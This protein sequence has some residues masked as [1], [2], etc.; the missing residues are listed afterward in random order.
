MTALENARLNQARSVKAHAKKVTLAG[1][2]EVSKIEIV[3]VGADVSAI[4]LASEFK[5]IDVQ[6]RAELS[7][8]KD[9]IAELVNVANKNMQDLS[10]RDYSGRTAS[11][12]LNKDSENYQGAFM[13]VAMFNAPAEIDRV[14]EK[15]EKD[16]VV[17]NQQYRFK[18]MAIASNAQV[19]AQVESFEL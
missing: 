2:A 16:V 8:I 13:N 1:I 19:I 3:K 14:K 15:F 11:D 6:L 18:F 17:L 12:Y 10:D 4:D 7:Q 5:E 9:A